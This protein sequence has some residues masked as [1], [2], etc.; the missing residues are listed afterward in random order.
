MLYVLDLET[1]I[2]LDFLILLA[3]HTQCAC[4][5]RTCV[6]VFVPQLSALSSA[7]TAA[8][9]LKVGVSFCNKIMFP[10]ILLRG[11]VK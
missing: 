6:S 3:P 7:L 11:F 10:R 8:F 9:Q 1:V 5:A 2:H 4:T